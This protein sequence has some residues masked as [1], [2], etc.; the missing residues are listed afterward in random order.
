MCLICNTNS[1]G[2]SYN[3]AVT[4][5]H[6][7]DVASQAKLPVMVSR[8]ILASVMVG[9]ATRKLSFQLWSAG[10]LASYGQLGYLPVMISW[11]TRSRTTLMLHHKSSFQLWSSGL[12]A[13][14]CDALWGY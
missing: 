7:Y 2:L 1:L 11:A 8:A 6:D 12:R 4:L 5:P 3:A 14:D 10:P 9:R 13:Y